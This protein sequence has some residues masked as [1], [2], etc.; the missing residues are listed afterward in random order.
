MDQLLD[1]PRLRGVL[2]LYGR[3]S[4]RV[5]ARRLLDLLRQEI[6]SGAFDDSD[7]DARIA[8]LPSDLEAAVERAEGF[9]LRRVINATGIFVHTNLGR[10]PLPPELGEELLPCSPATA[11]WRWTS[12][13]ADA[14]IGID[15]CRA[16]W[17][18]SAA[19]R[20]PSW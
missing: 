5:Q 16:G 2:G 12:R 4:V 11:I 3:A 7:L 13:P 8:E 20:L 19:P 17:S 1:E 6:S 9:G 18:V 15:S 10:A 14:A